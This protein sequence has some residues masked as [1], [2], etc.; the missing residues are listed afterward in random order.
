VLGLR[1]GADDYVVKPFGFAE[2]QARVEA[3]LRRARPRQAGVRR[4]GRLRVDLDRL[5]AYVDGEPVALTR[6]E[7]HLLAL[8]TEQP[9]VAVR[10]ERL[11]SEVWRTTWPGTSR[12]LDVHMAT[13]RAKIGDGARIQT[14][15]GTGYRIT[16]NDAPSAGEGECA[17]DC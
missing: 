12:T 13:L 17:D 7:F 3:V 14:I 5:C 10:R 6:K 15:R 11:F 9:E 8:L 1:R 2:L 4:V 16:A